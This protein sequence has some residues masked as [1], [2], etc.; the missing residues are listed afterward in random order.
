MKEQPEAS[1]PRHIVRLPGFAA[2]QVV[3]L[4]EVLGRT[5]S[6]F[7]VKPCGGCHQRADRV[8]R[9]IGFSGWRTK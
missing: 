4:G 3:G 7:G 2:G 9:W 5:T 8:N 6:A 1:Q